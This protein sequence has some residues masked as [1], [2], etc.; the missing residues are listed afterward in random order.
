VLGIQTN[1]TASSTT[2]L[3]L[4]N[5]LPNIVLDFQEK[6]FW[7]R[8]LPPKNQEDMLQRFINEI[9]FSNKEI[10]TEKKTKEQR[11]N[12][13]HS[14]PKE[15]FEENMSAYKHLLSRNQ[16]LLSHV[17]QLLEQSTQEEQSTAAATIPTPTTP[18]STSSNK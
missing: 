4:T 3:F 11:K 5:Q 12:S 18:T 14:L 15:I 1:P 8:L 13:S 17:R 9:L 10:L 16:A 7:L 6:L 2:L